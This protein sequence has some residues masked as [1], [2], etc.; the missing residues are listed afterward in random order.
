MST[1]EWFNL[2]PQDIKDKAIHNTPD[3]M[4]EYCG[5]NTLEECMYG[6]FSW[7]RSK[8]GFEFWSNFFKSISNV[9]KD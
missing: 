1:E 2:L 9:S 6:A 4:L 5:F 3:Y 8:E 7:S